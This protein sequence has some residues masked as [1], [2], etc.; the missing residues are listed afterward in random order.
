M[1]TVLKDFT[2]MITV[3]LLLSSTHTIT[4]F[5]DLDCVFH[6]KLMVHTVHYRQPVSDLKKKKKVMTML[7]LS[8]LAFSS[9]MHQL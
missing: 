3:L 4:S 5:Y 7:H 1:D 8:P 6:S 9:R 2:S